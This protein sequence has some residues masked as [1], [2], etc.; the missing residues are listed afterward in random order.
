VALVNM[1]RD[2]HGLGELAVEVKLLR[3][4]QARYP[5]DFW[6]NTMLAWIPIAP[7]GVNISDLP[8]CKC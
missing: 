4:G 3:A 5:G 1:A 7:C 2:L 6:I 8:G